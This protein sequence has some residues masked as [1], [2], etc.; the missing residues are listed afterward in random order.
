MFRVVVSLD[1]FYLPAVTFAKQYLLSYI[2]FFFH[3]RCNTFCA[4]ALPV[5][6]VCAFV[7][8]HVRKCMNRISVLLARLFSFCTYKILF[9]FTLVLFYL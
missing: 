6:C 4:L 7:S 5:L 8:V 1:K 2:C 3:C 9:L